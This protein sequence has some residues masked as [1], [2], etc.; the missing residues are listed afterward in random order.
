[1]YSKYNKP[2]ERKS[3]AARIQTHYREF[4]IEKEQF[5]IGGIS[6]LTFSDLQKLNPVV[7]EFS[8]LDD[9]LFVVCWLI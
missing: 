5:I 3:A 7:E 9:V 8:S 6:S 1:M 4:F 2:L